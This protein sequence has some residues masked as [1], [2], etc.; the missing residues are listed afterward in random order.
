[1]TLFSSPTEP[2]VVHGGFDWAIFAFDA[3]LSLLT[4]LL[5]GV[6][7]AWN[8]TRT[9]VSTTL[10]DNAQTAT[11]RRKGLAGKAIVGFQI[12]LS[13]LLVVAAGVFLRTLVN[14]DRV[15]PGFDPSN[16]ILFEISPPQA[17]YSGEKQI[18][19]FHQ[20]IERLRQVPGVE[21]VSPTSVPPLA[22]SYDNDDF[23]PIGAKHDSA[24]DVSDDAVVGD[25]Y[26][27]T[28]RIPIVAGRAFA[29]SDTETSPKVAVVNQALARQFFPNQN[30]IGKSFQT[31]DL[32]DN[33]ITYQI[34]GLSADTHYGTLREVPPPVFYLDYRQAPEIDWGMTFA[35]RTRTARAAL[36]PSLRQAIRSIDP[37]LPLTDIRT[38]QEQID[39]LLMTE[40]IFADLTAGFGLIAL[41]LACIGIYGIMAYSVSQRINEIGI[42]MALGAQ[43]ARVLRMVLGEA[44]WIAALGIVAGMGGALALGRLIAS[45]LYGLK[46]S[47]P[48]TL[49]A[50]ALLLVLVALAAS[51]IPARR[52]AGVDPMRALRHE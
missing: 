15:N 28:F 25:Q 48:A 2:L 47:D 10:K 31:S 39:E 4:G 3:A 11:R 22:H 34:V 24:K 49:T 19:L 37:N 46:P 33:K 50:S 21:S 44:S 40:R 14:L 18:L 45:M 9:Q 8:A 30:P 17:R 41:A 20:I 52:A 6:A 35:V 7:P 32:K 42:R 12:A 29:P 5:F 1:L 26:F 13:T 16:L 23:V 38:Q 51:W 27:S 43:P 36:T